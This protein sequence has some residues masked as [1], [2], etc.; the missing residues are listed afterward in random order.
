MCYRQN[1]QDYLN[2]IEIKAPLFLLGDCQNV[3]SAIPD[4]SIDCIITSPPY[5]GQRQYSGGGIGLENSF[6]EYINDFLKITKELHRV[7]KPTGSFWLNIGDT[8]RSKK[9]LGIPWRVS[10]RMMDEQNWILRNSVIW[11]KHK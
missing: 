8:Y 1:I 10:I 6:N 5:W 3:L 7:L 4:N 9:L 11:N 2:D